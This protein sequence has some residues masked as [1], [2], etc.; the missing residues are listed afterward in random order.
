MFSKPQ[1]PSARYFHALL[2]WKFRKKKENIITFKYC[3]CVFIR[4]MFS[5]NALFLYANFCRTNNKVI[6]F[7]SIFFLLIKH[8]CRNAENINYYWKTIFMWLFVILLYQSFY[9]FINVDEKL[10]SFWIHSNIFI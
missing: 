3:T 7:S 10:E 5:S 9:F 6:L 1:K 4:P 2:F 8:K